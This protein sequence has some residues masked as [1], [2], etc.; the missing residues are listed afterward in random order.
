MNRFLDKLF[1][2]QANGTNVSTE[3]LAG[4]TTFITMV[5]IIFVNP[6][7]MAASGMDQ[8]ASFVGTCL[9]AAIACF[10]MGLYANWPVGMAP[11]MG[12][13]AFFTYTVVGE[14]GYS[15][16]IALGAVF[17]AGIIF[18]IMSVTRLRRWMLDS[19]SLDL[20]I[21]MGAGVGLFVGFIG[22]KSGGI[23]VANGAT[24]LSLGDFTKPQTLLAGLSFLSIAILSIR[25]VPGAI[26]IG[27]LGITS[28]AIAMDLV[29]FNGLVAPPPSLAPTLMQLDIV[30]AF[31]VAMISVIIA[32]LFVN[33][34]DTAGTLLGVASRAGLVDEQGNAKNL[35][36]ALKADSSSSVLGAFFGCPPVT[37]YVESSA[38]VE[39]GGRTGL[40]AVVVGSLFLLAIFFS[41]LAAIVPPYAT[42]GALIYVAILMLSSMEALDWSDMTEILPAL[43]TIIMIPLSFSIAN[44][45]ALG[46]ITYV[47]VK[48]FAGKRADITL[49]AWFLAVIFLA[50]FTFL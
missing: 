40:T 42:A 24:F 49:G 6:Q 47:A 34:F 13:N 32:F 20:R 18:V 29:Q 48:F 22:L 17:L 10:V 37:S 3:V 19:I 23:I 9:A 41:P 39:A 5:Y 43:V 2:L 15:W 44:G 38:G 27:I 26:I 50:K 11:G 4:C 1:K 21:A 28:I 12:L 33:L 16:Q 30:G 35:D 25:R 31:D 7:M 8:G 45:I 46:F 14:M 36:R